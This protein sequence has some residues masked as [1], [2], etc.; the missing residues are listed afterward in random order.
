[1]SSEA[2]EDLATMTMVPFLLMTLTHASQKLPPVFNTIV[3]N[4]QGPRQKIYLE[5]SLLEHIYPMSIVTDGM[6]LNITV[7][8]YQTELCIGITSAPG[9]EPNIE[10]LGSLI[11]S[12]FKEL[13]LQSKKC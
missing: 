5:G 9:S 7:I 13:M 4:V 2:S 11:K 6:G 8:S 3:S 10:C 1:M 12:A